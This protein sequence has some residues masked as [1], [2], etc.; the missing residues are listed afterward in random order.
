MNAGLYLGFEI[1]R[2][3]TPSAHHGGSVDG[4]IMMQTHSSSLYP[5]SN[6]GIHRALMKRCG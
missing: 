6:P 4:S 2:M 3:S 1:S 5:L